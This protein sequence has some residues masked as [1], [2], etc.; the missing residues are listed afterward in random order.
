RTLGSH[1]SDVAFPSDEQFVEMG[2]LA[3]V[4]NWID[5]P[6]GARDA[7]FDMI[8]CNPTDHPRDFGNFS[9]ATF[10][11]GFERLQVGVSTPGLARHLKVRA[12]P[13]HRA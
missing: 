9:C 12:W 1:G 5:V 2:S 10:D 4:A 11:T 7:L 3:A 13:H 6:G 8:I